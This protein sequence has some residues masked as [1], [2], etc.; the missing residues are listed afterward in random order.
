MNSAQNFVPMSLTSEAVSIL[1]TT[2]MTGYKIIRTA[3]LT[4]V[5]ATYIGDTFFSYCGSVTD[6]N[7]VGLV[8]NSASFL[9]SRPRRGVK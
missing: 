4:F 7:P 3:P 1:K 8:F 2:G 6:N 5:G 9:L